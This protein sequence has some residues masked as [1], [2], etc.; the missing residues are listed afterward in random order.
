MPRI[1]LHTK[2]SWPTGKPREGE[3][4]NVMDTEDLYVLIVLYG[5]PLIS[6]SY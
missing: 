3:V 2:W 4:P 6:N 1:N 5:L